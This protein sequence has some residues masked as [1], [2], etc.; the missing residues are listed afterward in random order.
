MNAAKRFV[1]GGLAA[2]SLALGVFHGTLVS[3]V[4]A[5]ETVA[6]AV[7]RNAGGD[8]L[9]V[10]KFT[11]EEGKTLV[12]VTV[13]DLPPGFHGFHVHS[14]GQCVPGN[15]TSAG[16][17]FNP[18][19]EGHGHHAGDLPLLYVAAD[20]TGEARFTVDGFAVADLFDADGSALIVHAGPDNYA[21]IPPR[22][23]AAPDATTLATGDAGA[24][25]AC[26]LI[27]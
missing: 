6:H 11:E 13:H 20:G 15:F 14:I 27:R 3:G 18:G 16:G 8:E 1:V 21:N 22:Y 25:I 4:D 5:D 9:G 24:R 2:A 17:H 23:A 7:I 19:G 10:A 26:G 12:R